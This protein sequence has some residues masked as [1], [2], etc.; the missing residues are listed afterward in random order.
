MNS[1]F[2]A[3]SSSWS[4]YNDELAWSAAWLYKATADPTYLSKAESFFDE[5]GLAY[6]PTEFSW[7]N[8]VAGVQILLFEAT[9]ASK[10]ES[11]INAFVTYVMNEAQYTPK[12]L[13]FI[14][15]WGSLRHAS[16]IVHAC[17]QVRLILSYRSCLRKFNLF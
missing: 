9:S 17:V 6:T 16:N 7:D 3:F 8:K 10:Y 5:F 15:K 14:D 12:G 2:F 4:G 11:A 13:I 1:F